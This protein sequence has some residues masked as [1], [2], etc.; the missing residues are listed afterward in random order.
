[1]AVN[2]RIISLVGLLGLGLGS[3]LS[4]TVLLVP[5]TSEIYSAGRVAPLHPDGTSFPGFTGTNIGCTSCGLSN[6]QFIGAQMF[7]VGVFL[8][9]STV[10]SGANPPQ[11]QAYTSSSVLASSF[12]PALGQVFFIGDGQGTSGTQT[13]L[14]P[15]GAGRLFLGFA[16]DRED[17]EDREGHEDH[18]DH[19]DH[20]GHRVPEPGTL[21]LLSLGFAGLAI[22]RKKY[23][24]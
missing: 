20:E 12:A 17:R 15:A 18:E 24:A 1:M 14:V 11:L 10:P 22:G 8:D 19:E 7:L 5:S 4:A 16:D 23:A 6:I 9:P 3:T 2:F 21:A 13:F